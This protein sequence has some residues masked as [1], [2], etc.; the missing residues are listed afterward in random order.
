MLSA[1]SL[2]RLVSQDIA[3]SS[4]FLK[5]IVEMLIWLDNPTVEAGPLKTLLRSFAGQ[6]SHKHRLSD[7]EYASNFFADA[8]LFIFYKLRVMC[9]SALQYVQVSF[10]WLRRWHIAEI[11]K[12][13]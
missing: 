5:V 9:F 10:T 1:C 6:N 8:A 12:F 7:G 2:Q 3:F 13:H 4:L 11:L